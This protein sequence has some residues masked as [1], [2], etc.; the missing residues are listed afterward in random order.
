MASQHYYLP[1]HSLPG[2]V[3]AQRELALSRAAAELAHIGAFLHN[4]TTKCSITTLCVSQPPWVRA[5][6]A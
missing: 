4:H 1:S 3:P 2:H 6:T 5:C